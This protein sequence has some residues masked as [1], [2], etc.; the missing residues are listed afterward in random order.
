M[1][2]S[3]SFIITTTASTSIQEGV[4]LENTTVVG[5][6]TL[7]G[8]ASNNNAVADT[9]IVGAADMKISKVGTPATVIAGQYV[10]Y[11]IVITN[12]GPGQ[13]RSVDV[14]DQLPAG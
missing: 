7:D 12:T 6:S 10:T 9:S 5:S 8:N 14:K 13:A 1:G 11:T 2:T 3:S 4:S